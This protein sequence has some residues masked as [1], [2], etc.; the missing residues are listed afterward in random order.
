MMTSNPMNSA[1]MSTPLAHRPVRSAPDRLACGA[2]G[3]FPLL[4]T[5]VVHFRC[6]PSLPAQNAIM[7]TKRG[8]RCVYVAG[9]VDRHT[10][11]GHRLLLQATPRAAVLGRAHEGRHAPPPPLLSR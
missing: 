4:E 7:A 8:C 10:R 1:D 3:H 6:F 5:R 2:Q 11:L 9:R